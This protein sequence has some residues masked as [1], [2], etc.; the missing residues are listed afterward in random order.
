MSVMAVFFLILIDVIVTNIN[1]R[2]YQDYYKIEILPWNKV[3][4]KYLSGIVA[5]IVCIA[6]NFGLFAILFL[7][8]ISIT[9]SVA[10]LG[11]MLYRVIHSG[12][13]LV[14]YWRL[15]NYGKEK[16]Y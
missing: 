1:S 3:I 16:R 9:W 5:M 15:M 12:G 2:L 11:F 10:L 4:Y 14:Q 13:R 8:P 6:V 7:M